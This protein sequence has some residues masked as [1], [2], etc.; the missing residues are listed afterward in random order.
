[1]KIH[2]CRPVQE[3]CKKITTIGQIFR[4]LTEDLALEN[5]AVLYLDTLRDPYKKDGELPTRVFWRGKRRFITFA[6][7]I[8]QLCDSRS[9][10]HK[11][12]SFPVD[13]LEWGQDYID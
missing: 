6:R 3:C 11:D 4:D 10:E 2:E 13:S 8:L 9:C 5:L 1:M 7:I 12:P